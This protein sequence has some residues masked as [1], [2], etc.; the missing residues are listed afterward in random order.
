MSTNYFYT[1]FI[2]CNICKI[3]YSDCAI[4]T[5]ERIPEDDPNKDQ[6]VLE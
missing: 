2:H 4:F 3:V 5:L 1:H 6:N